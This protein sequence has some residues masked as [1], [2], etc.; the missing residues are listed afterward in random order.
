MAIKKLSNGKWQLKMRVGNTVEGRVKWINRQFSTKKDAEKF[1]REILSQKDKGMYVHPSSELFK[2][3]ITNWFETKKN[4]IG[5]QTA[6]NY[7]LNL[8]NYIIPMLGNYQ[9]GK[10]KLPTI[11]RFINELHE[12]VGLKPA[13]V[14]K[15]YTIVSAALNDAV[16]WE[17]IPKNPA[18]HVKLPKIECK[19]LEVWN[20]QQ[21]KQFL[22]VAKENRYYIVFYLALMT[23]MRQGEILG[24]RWKDI[25]FEKKQLSIYQTLSSDGKTILQG[26]KTVNSRRTIRL[27]DDTIRVLRSHY[28][29]VIQEK[30]KYRSEYVDN[31]LVCCTEKGT[32]TNPS[33]V[34]RL[35]KRFIRMS[36]VPHITFHQLRH[37]HATLLI[38]SGVNVKAVSQR[39]GHSDV[40]VTLDIYSHVTKTMEDGIAE[41]L[42]KMFV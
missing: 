33:N 36:G 21:V 2:D 30:M 12:N 15:I 8:K 7:T 10:L 42:D 3:F 24:L 38:E 17:Y 16:K 11:Q 25:D 37:T 40:R 1:E 18:Q 35:M 29:M 28:R 26:G 39:L 6:N 32:P 23:G 20:S 9:I 34:R 22:E 31:G 13:T 41:L 27:S 19:E 4:E 14:R 5:I